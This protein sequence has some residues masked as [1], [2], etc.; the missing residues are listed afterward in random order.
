MLES[1]QYI[2]E[3]TKGQT[4]DEFVADPKT[5][6]AV[7]RLLSVIGEAAN[8]LPKDI[9][10]NHPDVEWGRIIRSRNLIIHDYEII[11]YSVV[12][13]IVSVHLASL[14]ISLEKI[15]HSL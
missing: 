5:K 7:L 13:R 2:I 12:W 15:I 10:S 11:D 9:R 3:F 4:F 1:I 6:F 14:K 8:R